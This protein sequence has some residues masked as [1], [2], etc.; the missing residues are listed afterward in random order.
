MSEESPTVSGI[1][2]VELAMQGDLF[3]EVDSSESLRIEVED[4]LLEYIQTEVSAGTLSIKTRQWI[5]L[6]NT[7]P[8]NYF[9]TVI[10]LDS[11]RISSSGNIQASNLQVERFSITIS[12]A[13]SV[14]ITGGQVQQQDITISSSGQYLAENLASTDA[15]VTL[16]SSGTATIRVSDQLTGRLS[17][18]GNIYYIGDPRVSVSTTSSGKTVQVDK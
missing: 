5:N 4:N 16:T 11:I 1:S 13:G 3:I 2:G 7:E 8:I 15:D 10:E 6:R 14:E 12:S 17:S 9:L 18:S